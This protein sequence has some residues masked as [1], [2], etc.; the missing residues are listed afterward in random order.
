MLQAM[1]LDHIRDPESSWMCGRFGAV[2]EFHRDMGEPVDIVEGSTLIAA[3]ARGALRLDVLPDLRPVAYE[4]LTKCMSWGQGVALCLPL[5][6]ARMGGRKVVTELGPDVDAVRPQDRDALLFDLGIGGRHLEIC[7]RAAD[8]ET[9]ALLR[10][11]CG[12]PLFT[13]GHAFLQRLPALSPHRVFRC[14]LGRVEVYQPVPPPDGKS[15]DGPHTHVQQRLL[16]LGRSHA[17]T[18]PVPPG[19]LAGMTLYPPHPLH[20]SSGELKSFDR[21]RFEAFQ[22]L[23]RHYGDPALVAGKQ[24]VSADG[25][26]SRA[27]RVG[28]R[29]SQRQAAWL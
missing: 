9:V 25:L 24:A 15:P 22:D 7:V 27:E 10:T 16:S 29:I 23:L 18:V 26:S 3:T 4:T 8:P 13:H 21:A 20:Q 14:R 17:A 1:L 5:D 6:L 19:W 2:A 12:Q 11:I 28:F